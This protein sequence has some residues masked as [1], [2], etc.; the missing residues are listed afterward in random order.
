MPPLP[1]T[2]SQ[3]AQT[4]IESL[5]RKSRHLSETLIPELKGYS[6][7]ISKQQE[8]S[9]DVRESVGAVAREIE[10]LDAMIDDQRG[11]K[12]RR[13]LSNVV[14]E[15]RRELV[16]LRTDM[17]TAILTSKRAVDALKKSNRDELL[18]HPSTSEKDDAPRGKDPTLQSAQEDLTSAL[19]RT[20][21]LMSDSLATSVHTTQ[22]LQSSS[23]ALKSTSST[24]D[25]LAFT[26]QST[27]M[28]VTALE[29]SD[30]MDRVLIL[31]AF[32]FFLGVVAFVL[33][34]RVLDRGIVMLGWV[35]W[36]AKY[37]PGL[38]G[39]KTGTASPNVVTGVAEKVAETLKE[40]GGQAAVTAAVTTTLSTIAAVSSAVF[41]QAIPSPEATPVEESTLSDP[42]SMAL[43]QETPVDEERTRDE[44]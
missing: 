19:S 3:P 29:K 41:D 17:R 40:G 39:L 6:G 27:K 7:T 9:E 1:T 34:Q 22:L 10:E 20:L 30:W 4:L 31:S 14:E 23:A 32:A 13:D 16:D 21:A 43:P 37:V 18:Y 8:L 5:H 28:L 12:T 11:E 36:W 44:L 2:F 35:F 15:F 38:G 26:L 42:L 24:H 25:T 33:K